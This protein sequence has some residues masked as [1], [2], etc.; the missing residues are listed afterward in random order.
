[1]TSAPF[2][3][4]R[5]V[6][7]GTAQMYRPPRRIRPSEAC[8]K[9]LRN[10]RGAWDPETSPEMVE[11]LDLMASRQYQ[12][13]VIVGPARSGKTFTLIIG[14]LAYAVTSSPGDML[15]VQM[16][17]EVARDF[18]RTDV[19]RALHHSPELA[20]ALSPR[21]RDDNIFD[22]NF[23]SGM[24]AKFAWPK[25][26]QVSGKTRKYVVI[27]DYDRAQNRD[28]VDGEG[29]LWDLARKRTETYM[30][31]GK[32][33]A[34]SS[35]DA[36]MVNTK[37]RPSTPH[38]APPCRG[39]LELYNRGTR[40]RRYW[41]CLHCGAWFQAEPGLGNFQVP[42]LDKLEL[43]VATA[44]LHELAWR[45]ARISCRECGAVHLP[46]HKRELRLRGKWVHEGEEITPDGD[47]VGARIQTDIASFWFGGCAAAY[48]TWPAMIHR[49][50]QAVRTYVATGDEAP[51]KYTV[52]TDQAAV[53]IPP[54]IAKRKGPESLMARAESWPKGLL[55]QGV[56]FL[57]AA[58]DVQLGRFVVQIKGY[59]VELE[60]W[61]IDRF[62]ITSSKRQEGDRT[63]GLDPASYLEDWDLIIDEVADR[64]YPYFGLLDLKLSPRLTVVDSGGKAGVTP[65]AYDFYRRA[66]DRGYG[67]RVMLMKGTGHPAAPRC[68]MTWPDT[69][70]RADRNSGAAGDVP[71][72]MINTNIIKDGVA[73]DYA[74]EVPGPG[75]A[76]VPDWLEASWFDELMAETRTIKGWTRNPGQR[77]E[78]FDLE[79][80]ARAACIALEAEKI[81]WQAPPDWAVPPTLRL[82]A[83]DGGPQ[84]PAGRRVRDA[85]I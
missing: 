76:H 20:A 77:N 44:D 38:E 47:I 79:C 15:I 52:N 29:P 12:G 56:R 32:T 43:E 55:P 13:I 70:G 72:L 16:S 3:S 36:L 65:R 74:R 82:P 85:G 67:R 83:P 75:Y 6:T 41:P 10:E 58:V 11:P 54:A 73:N 45:Y 19:D 63:A 7:S 48:Q 21:P 28:N 59:G 71:V 57:V 84:R 35:P 69:R 30:S 24:E 8:A 51:L 40:A 61:L 26:S 31:R 60:S 4:V 46:E 14:A 39:I 81:N 2:G 18:S 25:V 49:Y 9:Y 53:H 37:W 80:Y 1:M 23:R 62:E 27:P 66:R 5:D 50:L 78:A 34:E 22:K 68:A 33:M 17:H 64:S 42:S